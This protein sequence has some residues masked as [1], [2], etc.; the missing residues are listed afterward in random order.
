[1]NIK[2]K[3]YGDIDEKTDNDI[4][5]LIVLLKNK[6]DE[7]FDIDLIHMVLLMLI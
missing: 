4:E 7:N 3:I 2:I 1:M 5:K 6:I